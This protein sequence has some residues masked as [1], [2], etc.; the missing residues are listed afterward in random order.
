[1]GFNRDSGLNSELNSGVNLA[2]YRGSRKMIWPPYPQNEVEVANGKAV[3]DAAGNFEI[4]FKA[5]PDA[6]IDQK[7]STRFLLLDNCRHYR[8]IRRN[9]VSISIGSCRLSFS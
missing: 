4:N 7:K 6:G 5:I 9:Q 2:I 3:T 8:H 1:M